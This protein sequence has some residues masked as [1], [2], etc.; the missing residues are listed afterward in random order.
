MSFCTHHILHAA[1]REPAY[2]GLLLRLLK[3]N[4]VNSNMAIEDNKVPLSIAA[5]NGQEIAIRLLLQ[6]DKTLV[7]A[8]NSHGQTPLLLAAENGHTAVVMMLIRTGKV[9]LSAQDS[10]GWT[11]LLAAANN[12]H[13][14]VVRLLLEAEEKTEQQDG[15]YTWWPVIPD[16]IQG[17]GGFS[18]TVSMESGLVYTNPKESGDRQEA[19]TLAARNRHEGVVMLLLDKGKV[20]ADSKNGDGRTS[21]SYA[22]ENGHDGVVKLLQSAGAS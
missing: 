12:G 3:T 7:D 18:C 15:E 6:V 1:K 5:R 14:A 16:H 21:L 10:R 4:V 19:L 20:D 17:E 11:P 22:A 8:K 9:A 13:A 2:P